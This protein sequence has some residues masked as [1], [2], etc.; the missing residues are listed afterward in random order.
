[1]GDT[2]RERL[3]D[4]PP[5][6]LEAIAEGWHISLTDERLEDIVERLAAEMVQPEAVASLLQRLSAPERAILA[7]LAARDQTRSFV[8][9]RRYGDIRRLGSGRLEWERAWYDPATPLE[10]LWFLGLVFRDYGIDQDYRGEVLLIPPEIRAFLPAPVQQDKTLRVSPA[11]PPVRTID[12]GDALAQDA[13]VL[14]SRVRN[15]AIRVHKGGLPA[16]EIARIAPRLRSRERLRLTFLQHLCVACGWIQ[17]NDRLWSI[18][19]ATADWLREGPTRRQRVLLQQWLRDPVWNELWQMPSLHCESTGWHNDPTAARRALLSYL[20]RC[21]TATWLSTQSLIQAIFALDPDFARPDG[22]YN[23]WYIRDA[24]TGRYLTGFHNWDNVEGAWLRYLLE[25]PLR[26]L[27][28][29]TLGFSESSG[30]PSSFRITP[31]GGAI[32]GVTDETDGTTEPMIIQSSM[33]VWVPEGASWYDRFLLERI[34]R[35]RGRE[36]TGCHYVLERDSVRTGVGQGITTTQILSF[37]RR[38]TQNHLPHKVISLVKTWERE[39]V[40]TA[41]ARTNP[42]SPPAETDHVGLEPRDG[43]ERP[44]PERS[45]NG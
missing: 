1:M 31:T 30:A 10:H 4:Y 14:L 3:A 11:P 7:E 29:V 6:M 33:D 18:T 17:P 2:L 13:F 34:A 39:P 21:P 8:I 36:S 9:T 44:H 5:I 19:Q 22:D 28:V 35:W 16:Q 15:H 23:S 24:R 20:V 45:H 40:P 38:V 25:H 26:W 43:Q 32:L 41:L 27:G 42:A 12:E 37:L